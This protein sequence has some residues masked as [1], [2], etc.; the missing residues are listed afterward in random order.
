MTTPTA[1]AL[2][3]VIDEVMEAP[4]T[5]QFTFSG[6]VIVKYTD[7][8][9]KAY[10]FDKILD[11]DV[12][13]DVQTSYADLITV[14]VMLN[15]ADY[16]M[17]IQPNADI[18]NVIL[19]S[20]QR[21]PDNS[22]TDFYKPVFQQEYKAILLDKGN[23]IIEANGSTFPSRESLEQAGPITVQFQLIQL[24]VHEFLQVK[25][26]LTI[27]DT[28]VENALKGVLGKY[29]AQSKLELALAP[30]GVKMVPAD[31]IEQRN[32][33]VI[34]HVVPLT[35]VPGYLQQK[36]GVYTKGIGYYYSGDYWHVW[37]LLD[38]NRFN[39]SNEKLHII[40]VP[41]NRL[42]GADR[43]FR[44]KDGIAT[45]LVTGDVRFVDPSEAFQ[46]NIGNGTAFGNSNNLASNPVRVEGNK[47]Y[48][49][50]KKN[51][52]VFANNT[53]RDGNNNVSLSDK[54]LSDNVFVE[55]SKMAIRDG[56]IATVVWK[57]ASSSLALPHKPVR[58]SY[59]DGETVKDLYGVIMKAQVSVTLSEQGPAAK[60]HT[61]SCVLTLFLERP[62]KDQGVK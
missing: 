42:T 61:S 34:D 2:T 28:T 32:H 16:A 10:L 12:I 41:T 54:R 45:I 14:S 9:N 15:R 31:N 60:N 11:I 8:P 36:I 3:R 30:K 39:Q 56:V 29:C 57:N 19:T 53:R 17:F 51:V 52:N 7:K 47:V 48:M 5:G 4:G 44:L 21:M 20:K 33:I 43:T 6:G 22:S 25:V 1:A 24:A 59:F 38:I 23:P 37:P 55:A 26:G 27:T 35:D 46:L 40:N 18:L 49:D 50:S 62:E 58:F 13:R